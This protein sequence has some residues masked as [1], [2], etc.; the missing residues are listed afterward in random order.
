MAID[1]ASKETTRILRSVNNNLNN[2]QAGVNTNSTLNSSILGRVNVTSA[3]LSALNSSTLGRVNTNSILISS[4]GNTTVATRN[5]ATS[6]SSM[7]SRILSMLAN[8]TYQGTAAHDLNFTISVYYSHTYSSYWTSSS[9]YSRQYSGTG[10]FIMAW[11]E[12][13][14]VRAC[15]N[16]CYHRYNGFYISAS[17]REAGSS[18][19]YSL[20]VSNVALGYN[21]R[22]FMLNGRVYGTASEYYIFS[23]SFDLFQMA[24][25]YQSSHLRMLTWSTSATTSSAAYAETR[26]WHW[27]VT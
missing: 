23:N 11:D 20:G 27:R 19:L 3:N 1:I 18:F 12:L 7:N 4:V 10:Y 16:S 14:T 13:S 22:Y 25:L 15:V 6:N 17:M 24:K 21:F 26:M 2:I 5:V 8:G 9:V